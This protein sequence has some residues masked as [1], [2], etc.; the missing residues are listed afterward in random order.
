MSNF[1]SFKASCFPVW[2]NT[3]SS[4]PRVFS[5]G[6]YCLILFSLFYFGFIIY[7]TMR[8]ANIFY[9]KKPFTDLF[10]KVKLFLLFK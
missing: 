5:L 6:H 3:F 4:S 2:I 8:W 9:L 7:Y 1:F 10:Y